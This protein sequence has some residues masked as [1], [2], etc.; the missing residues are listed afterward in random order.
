MSDTIREI[1]SQI[2]TAE[3]ARQDLIRRI[4]MLQEELSEQFMIKLRQKPSPYDGPR[5][6]ATMLKASEH[7]DEL[8]MEYLRLEKRLREMQDTLFEL[9]EAEK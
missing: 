1:K 7:L 4:D 5:V 2:R 3:K 8:E 6:D 9:M